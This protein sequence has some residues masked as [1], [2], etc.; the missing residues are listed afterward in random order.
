LLFQGS[1]G[2]ITGINYLSI[3]SFYGVGKSC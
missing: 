1:N 3:N 2:V